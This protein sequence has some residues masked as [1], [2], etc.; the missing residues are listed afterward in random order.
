LDG[1]GTLPSTVLKTK[2][3]PSGFAGHRP[4]NV[5]TLGVL[6]FAVSV[7]SIERHVGFARA[8]P[9]ARRTRSP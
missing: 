3:T 4:W 9:G 7:A 8:L 6:A 5:L 2:S 1:S